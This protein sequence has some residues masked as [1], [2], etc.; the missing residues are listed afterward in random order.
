M[1]K[2]EPRSQHNDSTFPVVWIWE[3]WSRQT[4]AIGGLR[5]IFGCIKNKSK[6]DGRLCITRIL[7]LYSGHRMK[8]DTL[9]KGCNTY[10]RDESLAEVFVGRCE[11]VK[12]SRIKHSTYLTPPTNCEPRARAGHIS[13]ISGLRM[14]KKTVPSLPI[15]SCRCRGIWKRPPRIN[16]CGGWPN[17]W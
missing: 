12:K 3:A 8:K 9:N 5:R 2:Y 14:A 10:G 17:A 13:Y 11:T 16:C 6:L 7:K 1:Q 15:L 4:C